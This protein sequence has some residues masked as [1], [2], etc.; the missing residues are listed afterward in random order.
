MVLLS[1]GVHSNVVRI[2]VPLTVIDEV[3]DEGLA[4]L[5]QAFDAASA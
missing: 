2:L 5:K 1:C 3:M 4:L